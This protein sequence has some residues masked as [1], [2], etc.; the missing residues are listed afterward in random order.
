[1]DRQRPRAPMASTSIHCSTIQGP[2]GDTQVAQV[3]TEESRYNNGHHSTG[4]GGALPQPQME[5][6]SVHPYLTFSDIRELIFQHSSLG[7]RAKTLIRDTDP[8][9]GDI[10]KK[11][12]LWQKYRT[13]C[14]EHPSYSAD[15]LS[16]ATICDLMVHRT[17]N[18]KRPYSTLQAV[19]D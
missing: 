11:N 14:L 12:S 4:S 10:K 19:G 3:A 6:E 2:N 16:V 13:F 8:D 5:N 18:C 15:P 17:E 1:M 7:L 9:T